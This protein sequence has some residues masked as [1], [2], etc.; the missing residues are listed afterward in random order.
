[1]WVQYK[2]YQFKPFVLTIWCSKARKIRSI[3]LNIKCV[4]QFHHST[5]M[6]RWAV[7]YLTIQK[8]L[9]FNRDN[10]S[11]PLNL[12]KLMSP[13]CVFAGHLEAG[14]S[15]PPPALCLYPSAKS[16]HRDKPCPSLLLVP[17]LT[18][19]ELLRRATEHRR[20]PRLLQLLTSPAWDN[21]KSPPP[22]L[23]ILLWMDIGVSWFYHKN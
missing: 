4:F 21:A 23:P 9:S 6:W 7:V 17:R 10:I 15:S 20:S 13:I 22:P 18:T 2:K 12:P 1:M 11:L 19:A 5:T 8:R 14:G 16:P 3:V